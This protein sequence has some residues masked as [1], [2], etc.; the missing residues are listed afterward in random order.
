MKSNGFWTM[1]YVQAQAWG[2]FSDGARRGESCFH[3]SRKIH[4][5]VAVMMI[6]M[7]MLMW[8]RWWWWHW[9]WWRWWWWR[10]WWWCWRRWCGWFIL[11]PRQRP[12]EYEFK[13]LKRLAQ[14]SFY[15]L[16]ILLLSLCVGSKQNQ[17]HM[18][19][20][21]SDGRRG[22]SLGHCLGQSLVHK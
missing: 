21:L 11:S 12:G 4:S 14:V 15:T 19:L 10:W 22:G 2:G 13:Y 6:M 16:V 18:K 9:C 7:M 5:K 1:C 8:I 3:T 20:F 17:L